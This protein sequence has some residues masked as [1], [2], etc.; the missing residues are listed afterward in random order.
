MKKLVLVTMFLVSGLMAGVT[1]ITKIKDMYVYDNFIVIKM[2]NKHTN[3]NGCTSSSARDYLYVPTNTTGGN[4][5]Y[6]A[7][8]SAYVAQK[9]VRLGYSGCAQWGS[10]TIPKVYG[11]SMLK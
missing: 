4:R 8:L 6:S 10:S 5:M 9:K 3:S 11:F 2:Q 1:S 7:I